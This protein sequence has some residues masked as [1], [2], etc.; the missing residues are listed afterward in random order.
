MDITI[1]P[2]TL[3]GSVDIIESK[4]QVHRLLICAALALRPCEIIC[5]ETSQ[6]IDATVRCLTALG[7]GITRSRTGFSVVPIAADRIPEHAVM[8]CGE[9][10]STLRFLLPV[11]G[12]LGVSASVHMSGRLPYRPL[13]PLL[14]ELRAHGITADRVSDGVIELSGKLRHGSFT[15]PGDLSS[16]FISGLLFALP[17]LDGD[18]SIIVTGKTESKAYIDMTADVLS[19]FGVSAVSQNGGFKIKGGQGYSLKSGVIAAEGDWSNCAFWLCAGAF[20]KAGVTCGGLCPGSLQGDREIVD[21]LKRFGALVSSGDESVSVSES[22]MLGLT[23]DAANIPDLVP[24][25]AVCACRARG[26][27]H[28]VNA[29]RLR[30]KESDRLEAVSQM[31]S[32]L[33]TDIEETADGLIINGCGYLRGG[34]SVCS[35]GDHRIAMSAAIA[36]CICRDKITVTGAEC[37]GKSYPK[38]WEHFESLGGSICTAANIEI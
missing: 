32:L 12:A 31:L 29:G 6:D 27:T 38:F 22:K 13:E 26:T 33:G 11:A 14:S 30:I 23:I 20:S 9:S 8:D 37:V 28:I 3:S 17:M 4:S 15:I 24:I 5:R 36:S 7:A 25:L 19:K 2:R 21:I 1:T 35:C 16:Q 18:S 10:G 34:V